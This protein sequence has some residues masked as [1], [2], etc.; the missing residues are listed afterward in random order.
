MGGFTDGADNGVS[1]ELLRVYGWC[2]S[3]TQ[4]MEI[5]TKFL[6]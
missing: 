6:L 2:D 5:R 1:Q 4:G 3:P